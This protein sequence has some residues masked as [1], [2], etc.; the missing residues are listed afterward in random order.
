[1][2]DLRRIS[3]FPFFPIHVRTYRPRENI[4]KKKRNYNYNNNVIKVVD[5]NILANGKIRHELRTEREKSLNYLCQSSCRN[6]ID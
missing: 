4:Q 6:S 5:K 3:F 2:R 1:M